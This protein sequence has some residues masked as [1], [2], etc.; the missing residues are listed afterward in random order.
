MLNVLHISC[1]QLSINF[2]NFT[3]YKY[4]VLEKAF[5]NTLKSQL[6]IYM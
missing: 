2:Q 1:V 5:A 6:N 4:I 3:R